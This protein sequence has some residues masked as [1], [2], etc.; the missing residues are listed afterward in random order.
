MSL[1][2]FLVLFLAVA[3]FSF[4]S[5]IQAVVENTGHFTS[6]NRLTREII[7]TKIIRD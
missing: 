1:F 6:V 3:V 2:S 7:L 5:I 4:V